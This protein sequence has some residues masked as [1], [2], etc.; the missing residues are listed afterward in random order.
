MSAVCPVES[1]DNAVGSGKLVCYSCWKL[2]PRS[3]GARLYAAWNNGDE[4]DDY[5]AVREAVL[6]LL[7]KK[8]AAR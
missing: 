6:D 7:D 4:T 8:R 3:L 5:P 1:C 2:V